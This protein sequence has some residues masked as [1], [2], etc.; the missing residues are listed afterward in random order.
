MGIAPILAIRVVASL[1]FRWHN[2]ITAHLYSYLCNKNQRKTE[3]LCLFTTNLWVGS[4][5]SRDGSESIR[6]FTPSPM[7]NLE[8]NK[9]WGSV[10]EI[11]DMITAIGILEWRSRQQMKDMITA[12]GILEWRSRQQ[13]KD[14]ITAIGILEWRSRQQIK[15]MITAIGILEWRSRQPMKDM[16]TDEGSAQRYAHS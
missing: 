10:T 6:L 1:C 15:D 8:R 11:K 16:I 4:R 14:M 13:M 2:N 7:S 5:P 3:A 12:I 9:R